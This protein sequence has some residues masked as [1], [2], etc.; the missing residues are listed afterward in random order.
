MQVLYS[1][2]ML[3]TTYLTAWWPDPK[4]PVYVLHSL[5][6]FLGVHFAYLCYVW[7]LLCSHIG[8]RQNMYNCVLLLLARGARVDFTNKAGDSPLDC[9][10]VENNDCYV[11]INLN[12]QLK[13]LVSNSR[14]RTQLIL[15]K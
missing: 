7:F 3:V 11:A 6:V 5:S 2:I 14:Q 4:Y 13:A 8:A 12:I 1:P 9:C 10:L 15:T